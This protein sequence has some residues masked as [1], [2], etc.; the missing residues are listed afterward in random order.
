MNIQPDLQKLANK[1]RAVLVA[2]Y[3]KTGKGESGE[4]DVFI[5]LTVPQMR[6]VAKK[7][8]DLALGEV[9]KLLHN[10]IHEYRLTALLILTEQFRKADAQKQ[11]K[12][13]S[14]YL[15]NTR[16]INNWDLVDLSAPNTL[17]IYLL[18]KPKERKM[19]YRFARSKNIWERRIS[20]LATFAFIK[21]G[22]FA[23][24]FAIAEMLLQDP[25]DLIHKAV[26][27]MLREIGKRDQAAEETFLKKYYKEMPRTMLRYAIERFPPAK[28]AVYLRN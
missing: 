19:L 28:R 4:G 8:W 1:Q 7:Y 9:E 13:I 24:S 14:L 23:D 10:K 2:R 20:V 11:K 16:Y 6:T 15:R 17:G 3:F 22:D 25:H 5:G 27:W 18:D 26:G 12:I 21:N